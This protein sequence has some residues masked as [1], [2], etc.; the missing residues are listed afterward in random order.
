MKQLGWLI[1]AVIL[2]CCAAMVWAT[3]APQRG[4]AQIILE[5]GKS[6]KVPFPHHRHQ[7][8][9]ADCM[10]CHELFPQE[11]GAVERLKAEGQL[12]TKQ[13]MNK[14]CVKCH[15]ELKKANQPSGPVTCKTCHI[16]D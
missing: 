8:N 14:L 1:V 3:D 9:Q 5:G 12:Q 2:T 6:G 13:V 4:Q 16:K 15:R 7:E 10:A 11:T